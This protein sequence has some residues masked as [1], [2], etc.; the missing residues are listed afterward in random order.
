MGRS[1]LTIK[2]YDKIL[3]FISQ[4]HNGKGD[5]RYELLKNI[6]NIFSFNYLTFHLIDSDGRFSSPIGL[7]ISGQLFQMYAEYYFKTDIFHPINMGYFMMTKKTIAITDLMS[8][9]QFEATEYYKDF[10][11]KDNLYYEVAM[12]LKFNNQ[13]IGALGIFRPKE[14]GNFTPRDYEI[15]RSLYDNITYQLHEYLVRTQIKNEQQIYKNCISQLPIGMIV[16]DQRRNI[17]NSNEIA[18]IY[19]LDLLSETFISDPVHEVVQN[20][21]PNI[22]FQSK[23]STSAIYYELDNYTIKIVPSIVPSMQNGVETY[24]LLY[25]IKKSPTKLQNVHA[26][27]YKYNLTERQLEIVELLS[28]GFSNKEIASKLYISTHTVRT[29]MDNIFNKLNVS[30]RTAILF[31]LGFIE[32]TA[33]KDLQRT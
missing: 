24:Y 29:H 7:N 23:D 32:D 20:I 31:K 9:K 14:E 3:Q 6:S 1:L 18:K 17:I 33:N 12:P 16:L 15:L 10:L 22:S 8:L 26:F 25:I 5:Y 21:L 28:Q 30:S 2:D 11:K 27:T 19:C 13:L 4:I